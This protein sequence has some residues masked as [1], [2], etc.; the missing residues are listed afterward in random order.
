M[1]EVSYDVKIIGIPCRLELAA[2]LGHQMSYLKGRYLETIELDELP[3]AA[4]DGK[5]GIKYLYVSI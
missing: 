2:L 1:Q 4:I 3:F 5:L